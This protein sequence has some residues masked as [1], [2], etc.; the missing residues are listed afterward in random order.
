MVQ[1]TPRIESLSGLHVAVVLL[2]VVL[3]VIKRLL[4]PSLLFVQAIYILYGF[5]QIG[6]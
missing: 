2:E 6:L 4:D 3:Q 5:R 1:E